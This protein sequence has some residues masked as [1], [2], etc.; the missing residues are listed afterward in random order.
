[1]KYSTCI[2]ND[3]IFNLSL[4]K[5]LDSLIH[6]GFDG[7]DIPADQK[8]YSISKI[9]PILQSYSNKLKIGEITA[10]MNP[11]RDL[12]HPEVVR[13]KIALDYIKYCIITASELGV[14]FT[15]FCFLSFPDNLTSN[16]R[17]V[18]E[19]R[20]I[21]SIKELI[22][23]AD[24]HH[25]RLLMEPLFKG[26]VSLIN[27][28]DQAVDLFSKALN[29][30]PTSFLAGNHNYGLLLDLFHMHHE[31]PDMFTTLRTYLPITYHVHVADHPRGLDFTRPDSSFVKRGMDILKEKNYS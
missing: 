25:V 5:I 31:E 4:D 20:A 22:K 26:D 17:E 10:C 12:I 21:E 3:N 19:K 24:D 7:V 14:N 11:T 18:L 2:T 30:D 8:S 28:A 23:F 29:T 9:Q 6:A 13:R 27:R 1:M 15:H 16:S